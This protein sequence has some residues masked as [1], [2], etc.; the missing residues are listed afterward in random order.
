M[1]D[2]TKETSSG[3]AQVGGVPSQYTKEM[4]DRIC[5]ELGDGT[6]IRRICQNEWAPSR[7]TIYKWLREQPDFRKQYALAQLDGAHAWAEEAVDI[8]DDGSNDWMEVHDKDNIGWR[9]NG[10]HVQRSKLRVE[11]RKWYAGR[12]NP[13]AYGE[14]VAIIGDDDSPP[15]RTA[16]VSETEIARRIAFALSKGAQATEKPH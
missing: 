6:S 15:I 1:S 9:F 2:E 7:T 5:A 14:K 4:G 8:A 11:T 16:D 13:K 3:R 12:M 10:E